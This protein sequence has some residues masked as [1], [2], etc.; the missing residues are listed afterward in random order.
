MA[1]VTVAASMARLQREFDDCSDAIAELYLSLADRLI[2][3]RIWMRQDVEDLSSLTV[4]PTSNGMALYA[5]GADTVIRV[6]SV[7]YLRSSSQSNRNDL[8]PTSISALDIDSNG[9][10]GVAN[11]EPS[12]WYEA[13]DSAGAL[14][15]GLWPCP[16]TASSGGYP[17][18]R[19]HV[20]R[21]AALATGGSLPAGLQ[22]SNAHV[23]GAAWLYANDYRSKEEAD[24]Y[25]VRF[26]RAIR[27]EEEYMYSFAS[28]DTQRLSY[29]L[30][31]PGI[32]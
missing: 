8:I 30:P 9:W 22:S 1:A 21:S 28:Y 5:F 7:E 31:I 14:R 26:E 11:S 3:G 2:S 24:Q 10:R 25:E 16:V 23:W 32:V 18:V 6:A 27:T 17:L 15:L 29:D 20:S 4:G 12:H 19:A 13:R